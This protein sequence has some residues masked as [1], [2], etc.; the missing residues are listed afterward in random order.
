MKRWLRSAPL[1]L[2]RFMAL[3]VAAQVGVAGLSPAQETRLRRVQ[4]PA[5]PLAPWP[6]EGVAPE[7]VET[8]LPSEVPQAPSDS[9]VPFPPELVTVPAPVDSSEIVPV[10]RFRQILVSDPDRVPLLEQLLQAGMSLEE[11]KQS[12]GITDVDERTRIY[13]VDELA[14]D[15]QAEIEALPDSGWS[16][17]R[18]WRGRTAFFQVLERDERGRATL[19]VLGENLDAQERSHLAS[20]LRKLPQQTQ[21]AATGLDANLTPAA[22]VEQVAAEYPPTA[23]ESGE[24][25]LVV[26]VGRLGEVQNVRVE[27]STDRIFEEPAI[28]AARESKYRAADRDGFPEPGTVRLIYKFAAPQSPGAADETQQQP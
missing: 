23:T 17:G 12:L 6:L 8:V 25:T 22:V 20:S 27:N 24:V 19:P 18:P 16:R 15:I 10:V 14:P 26:E 28:T 9:L 2:M 4:P 1:T 21:P 13:A 3:C 11:A 5:D 7:P